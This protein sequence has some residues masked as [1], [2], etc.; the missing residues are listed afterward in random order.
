MAQELALE[1]RPHDRVDGAERLVH[2]QHRRVGGKRPRHADALP[3]PARELAR[4]ARQELG[5]IEADE[6]QQL[7]D[8]RP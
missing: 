4:V 2:E 7:L 6:A 3:L 8:A 1:A 5:R